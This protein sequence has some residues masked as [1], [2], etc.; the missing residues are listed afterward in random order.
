[1]LDSSRA[2]N[3]GAGA[4]GAGARGSAELRRGPRHAR[5]QGGGGVGPPR[6]PRVRAAPRRGDVRVHTHTHALLGGLWGRRTRGG[7]TLAASSATATQGWGDGIYRSCGVT[8]VSV[9]AGVLRLRGGKCQR[10]V[11]TAAAT[12][13]GVCLRACGATGQEGGVCH[14]EWLSR[15]YWAT[16]SGADK[17][18]RTA[19]RSLLVTV[20]LLDSSCAAVT[21]GWV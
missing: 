6:V 5:S 13:R 3:K 7:R 21:Q 19:T 14:C 11:H 16:L 17:K 20:T 15:P 4:R 12:M 8:I 1:M 18:G 2:A 10:A 9:G